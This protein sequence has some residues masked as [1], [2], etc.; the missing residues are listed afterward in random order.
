MSCATKLTPDVNMKTL[1][2]C[3]LCQNAYAHKCDFH[4]ASLDWNDRLVIPKLIYTRPLYG[5][6][7]KGGLTYKV[8]E[9]PNFLVSKR[10]LKETNDHNDI[11]GLPQVAK[12][13]SSVPSMKKH[14][15]PKK[16][17]VKHGDKA[18]KTT[19]IAMCVICGQKSD[20]K[21]APFCS[22]LCKALGRGLVKGGA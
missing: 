14:R 16:K 3:W 6:K 9:C 4:N 18:P 22:P 19:D 8:A 2:L 12:I 17:P 15:T 11:E 21:L 20:N 10:A 13:K 1:S 7:D 5:S